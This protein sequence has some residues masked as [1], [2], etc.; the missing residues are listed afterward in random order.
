MIAAF[1]PCPMCAGRPFKG[2]LTKG[3]RL[4]TVDLLVLASLEQL[5]F[6]LKYCLPVFTK[7]AM[8]I[9][10]STVMSLLLQ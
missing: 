3:G 1:Q 6:I 8:L 5:I 9:R 10:R 7:Q 2:R 4:S